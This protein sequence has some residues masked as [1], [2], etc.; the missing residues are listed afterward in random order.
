MNKKVWMIKHKPTGLYYRDDSRTTNL[1]K[2]NGTMYTKKPTLENTVG[3][4][5]V[6]GK[7]KVE[8]EIAD[9]YGLKVKFDDG[10]KTYVITDEHYY[11]EVFEVEEYDLILAGEKQC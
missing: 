9:E 2:V 8:G 5:C 4:L 7:L 1:S 6:Y 10:Y 3:N 11:G